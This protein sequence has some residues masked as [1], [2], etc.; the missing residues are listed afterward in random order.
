VRHDDDF[1]TT[2][3]RFERLVVEHAAEKYV[4]RL[5]VTGMT[6]R[7]T[8]AVAIIK[9]MCEE[10]LSGNYDLEVVDVYQDPARA[11]AEQI[12]AAPTLVKQRPL[13][14]RRLIGNLSNRER[15]V[16]ALRLGGR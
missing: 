13:P 15:V 7:S 10:L 6:P 2:T 5:Y 4:L 3:D 16:R 1:E 11:S 12:V 8:E 9:A 14:E